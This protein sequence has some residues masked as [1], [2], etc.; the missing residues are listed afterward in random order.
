MG[1]DEN[2][3]SGAKYGFDPTYGKDENYGEGFVGGSYGHDFSSSQFGL[4]TDPRTSNQL[5]AVSDKLST[6]AKTIEVTGVQQNILESIPKQQLDEINRLRKLTGI[7]LT[8]HGP[9]VEPTGVTKQGWDD[10]HRQQAERQMWSAV[11]RA[12]QMDPD[13]NIVVTFHSSNGLPEPET[14]VIDERTGK[15][16]LKELWAVNEDTGQFSP[17]NLEKHHFLKHETLINPKEAALEELK[18]KNEDAWYKALQHTNFSAHAGAGSIDNAKKL[19]SEKTGINEERKLSENLKEAYT[20]FTKGDEDKLSKLFGE[21]AAKKAMSVVLNEMTHGDIYL[22]EAYG[23]LQNLFDQAYRTAKL[24]NNKEDIFKLEKYRDKIQPKLKDIKNPQKIDEF[25]DTIVEGINVLRSIKPPES[26][27]PLK[28][29]AIDKA[30]DTFSNLALSAYNKFADSA[31]IISIENPPVG[32]GLSRADELKELIEESQRKF[33]SKA[34]DKGMSKSDAEQQAKKLIGATW[35][36]GHI[37]M[38]RKYGYSKEDVVGEAEKIGKHLK[39]VHLSDNFGMEHTEL[40][41]GMGNVPTERVMEILGKYNKQAKKII[42]TGGPWF[43]FFQKS[44]LVETF[45]AFGS[46]IY[47]MKNSP[48]WNQ[49]AGMNGA[50]AYF[51]GYGLN[52]DIHHNVL[53]G[54]GFSNLPLELGGQVGGGRNRLSGAPME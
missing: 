13:G 29:F 45:S 27:K 32:M 11:E 48:Y 14:W 20:S 43:Q 38:L 54:A 51:A 1:G 22:R 37:N 7:D 52:P 12:H 53:Y 15:P 44:P 39:H 35:D 5:K 25:A 47:A 33:V 31:P 2:I 3:Y 17:V 21:P 50:G 34:V 41:M 16:D 46:P 19:Y 24:N 9:L 10:T 26:L 36:V 8:F 42:E 30:S 49:S 28:A 6:G 40:P 18:R 23:D 4:T